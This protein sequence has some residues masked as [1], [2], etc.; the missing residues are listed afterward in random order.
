MNCNLLDLACIQ[1]HVPVFILKLY[2]ILEVPPL[3]HTEKLARG[4]H[5]LGYQWRGNCDT[6]SSQARKNRAS[7]LLPA[8]QTRILRTATQ[9]VL[10]PKAEQMFEGS[11]QLSVLP[12][13][14]L[15]PRRHVRHL[16]LRESL[17]FIRRKRKSVD[18][19]REES[20][21]G[22]GHHLEI[23]RYR[24]FVKSNVSMIREEVSKMIAEHPE[25]TTS[26]RR[27][28]DLTNILLGGTKKELNEETVMDLPHEPTEDLYLN[29]VKEFH[30]TYALHHLNS[31][32]SFLLEEDEPAIGC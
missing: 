13:R 2:S 16:P 18:L 9:H 27:V 20:D 3:A 24:S 31:E 32:C 11:K 7:A 25:A 29:T 26:L 15:P 4:N 12:Q 19:D 30:E 17:V 8:Q 23:E 1:N 6:G 21:S 28:L 10:L 22:S 14:E 5:L